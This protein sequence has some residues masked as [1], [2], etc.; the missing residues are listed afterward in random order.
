MADGGNDKL[1]L[2]AIPL[3][4]AGEY[5]IPDP[6][7]LEQLETFVPSCIFPDGST[8]NNIGLQVPNIRFL[9]QL[10]ASD[11]S[12]TTVATAASTPIKGPNGTAVEG[13]ASESLK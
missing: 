13:L 11:P 4:D 6:R 12:F 9:A 5:E 8:S 3:D 1:L 2:N 10:V 7:A